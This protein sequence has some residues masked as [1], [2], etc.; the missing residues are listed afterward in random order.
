MSN[1]IDEADT[2]AA[3]VGNN[4][5]LLRFA[6]RWDLKQAHQATVDAA[7]DRLNNGFT[8]SQ[9]VVLPEVLAEIEAGR[10]YVSLGR[11]QALAEVYGVTVEYLRTDHAGSYGDAG[12][13]PP[14]DSAQA[15]G[16]HLLAAL[17]EIGNSCAAIASLYARLEHAIVTESS[18]Q[19]KA[20]AVEI[21]QAVLGQL[22]H[23][24]EETAELARQLF[25]SPEPL[26]A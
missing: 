23:T 11:L 15:Y 14:P 19:S 8:I 26:P 25:N 6:R 20:L 2:R 1:S 18:E 10:R 12:L 7:R 17:L 4:L 5:E 9:G 3:V 16:R 21:Q 13:L 24:L 22:R